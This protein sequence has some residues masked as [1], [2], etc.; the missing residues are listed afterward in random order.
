MK[1][2]SHISL[3]TLKSALRRAIASPR[4]RHILTVLPSWI[5][6]IVIFTMLAVALTALLRFIYLP[7]RIEQKPPID[8][9]RVPPQQFKE[10][11]EWI[12][13]SKTIIEEVQGMEFKDPF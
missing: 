8:F 6:L 2:N 13:R 12:G 10:I 4:F 11:T 3:S 1:L 5:V 9:T 7:S